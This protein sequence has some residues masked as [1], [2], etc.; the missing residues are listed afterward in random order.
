MKS[1][2]SSKTMWINFA[3]AIASLFPPVKEWVESNPDN[4]IVLLA[5][6]NMILRY[7]TQQKV[8]LFPE[9]E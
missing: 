2:F 1:V 9:K 6:V 4:S 7:I 8:S 3:M 5:S